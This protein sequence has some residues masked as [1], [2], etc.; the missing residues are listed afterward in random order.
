MSSLISLKYAWHTAA[1]KLQLLPPSRL[2]T[3]GI[4]TVLTRPRES[5]VLE[6]HGFS[7]AVIG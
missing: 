5:A 6:G 7:R 3:F 1:H 4:S 2:P